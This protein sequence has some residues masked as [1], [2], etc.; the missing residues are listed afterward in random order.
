VT[1]RV[2]RKRNPSWRIYEIPISYSG[3]IYEEGK[4]IGMKDAFNAFYC[5]VRY[6]LRD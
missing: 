1:A 5:I 4:K 3:R 2:A 6:W